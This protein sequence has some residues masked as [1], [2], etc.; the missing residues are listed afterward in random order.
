[1]INLTIRDYEQ[2]VPTDKAIRTSEYDLAQTQPS[3]LYHFRMGRYVIYI[4]VTPKTHE[5]RV[6]MKGIPPF[7][8]KK[9][10][11]NTSKFLDDCIISFYSNV[12][13]YVNHALGSDE[14]YI[15]G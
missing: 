2:D 15:D 1:M 3:S 9:R 14:V 6:I 8:E 5:Y 4:S 11:L 10:I 12:K 7:P 13:K